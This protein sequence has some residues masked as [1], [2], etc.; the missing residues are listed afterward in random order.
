MKYHF[1]NRDPQLIYKLLASTI[2]PRPIAWVTTVDQMGISNAAPFSFF[3]MMGSEPPIV[4]LGI[5]HSADGGAKDTLRNIR[6]QKIFGINLVNREDA[7][8][9]NL[10]SRDYDAS[11]DELKEHQIEVIV[12]DLLPIP[13]IATSPV[14]MECRLYQEIPTGENQ[15]VILGEVV[16]LHLIDEALIDADAGYV[17]ATKLNLVARMHGRGWYSEPDNLFE[18]LRP[19]SETR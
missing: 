19:D 8:L 4:A 3:N 14:K 12:G 17:D 18:M 7:E 6:E 2:V 16:M 1:Q 5:Q 10:T 13:L 15:A 9:M 11:A